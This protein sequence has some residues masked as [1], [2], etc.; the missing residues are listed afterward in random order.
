MFL[1]ITASFPAQSEQ[2]SLTAGM[3]SSGCSLVGCLA[4]SSAALCL[5]RIVVNRGIEIIPSPLRPSRSS[6]LSA[7]LLVIHCLLFSEME[8]FKWLHPVSWW[9]RTD[10]KH[11][12]MW[13]SVCPW[14]DRLSKVMFIIS[15]QFLWFSVP[16]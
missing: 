12:F 7:V 4:T 15:M 13:P 5:L 9:N 11:V 1:A 2:R 3:E 14:L 8:P 6:L 16:F 10:T